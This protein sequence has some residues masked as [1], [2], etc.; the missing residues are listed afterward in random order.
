MRH[1]GA[2][3]RVSVASKPLMD[4][5]LLLGVLPDI[6]QQIFPTAFP[7]QDRLAV[8]QAA[9]VSRRRITRY[10]LSLW[11][12]DIFFMLYPQLQR[13]EDMVAFIAEALGKRNNPFLR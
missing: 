2:P 7:L 4:L 10:H 13:C 1:D 12:K 11:V 5:L 8:A 3:Q 9:T 6:I